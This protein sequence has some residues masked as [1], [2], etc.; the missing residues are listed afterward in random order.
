[1]NYLYFTISLVIALSLLLIVYVAIYNNFQD[2][3]LRLKETEK[4]IDESLRLKY[5]LLLSI[6]EKMKLDV[7]TE[8]LKDKKISSFDFYRNITEVEMKIFAAIGDLK[9]EVVDEIGKTSEINI[10]IEAEI[11]YYNDTIT[12]YNINFKRFPSNIVSKISK[13]KP[14]NYFDNRNL[15]DKNKKD[16]KL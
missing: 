9:N 12:S 10:R 11:R 16:F 5:D 15:Y 2:H 7:E 14:K 8:D 6:K 13:M 3:L 4:E 1:M